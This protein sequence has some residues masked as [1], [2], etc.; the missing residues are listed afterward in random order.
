MQVLVYVH[1]LTPV[2]ATT[3]VYIQFLAL[4]THH[5][6]HRR[7]Q[8]TLFAQMQSFYANTT[9]LSSQQCHHQQSNTAKI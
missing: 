7:P 8:Q 5:S 4:T 6:G 3:V 2:T 9:V 1:K